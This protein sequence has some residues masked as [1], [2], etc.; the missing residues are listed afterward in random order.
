MTTAGTSVLQCSANSPEKRA[1]GSVEA[2][3]AEA[4]SAADS[5]ATRTRPS[6]R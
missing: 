2:E 1:M 4:A 3:L 5:G 6:T